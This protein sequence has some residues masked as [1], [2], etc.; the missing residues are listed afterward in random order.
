MEDTYLEV[1]SDSTSIEFEDK[2]S[3]RVPQILSD[4]SLDSDLKFYTDLTNTFPLE[5]EDRFITYMCEIC[6]QSI[7]K[8]DH[9]SEFPSKKRKNPQSQLILPSM[10]I[11]KDCRGLNLDD[12]KNLCIPNHGKIV[13]KR[14]R[15]KRRGNQSEKIQD[16]KE[17]Q[18]KTIEENP[19]LCEIE[20]KKLKQIIRNRISAQQSR[21]RKKVYLNK[22]EEDNKELKL[23]NNLLKRKV[24]DLVQENEYLKSQLSGIHLSAPSYNRIKGLGLGL[25]VFIGLVVLI[26]TDSSPIISIKKSRYLLSSSFNM[27]N[28]DIYS[29]SSFI[30]QSNSKNSGIIDAYR[31]WRINQIDQAPLLDSFTH[32]R[33]SQTKPR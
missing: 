4:I 20:K 28:E 1:I 11:C 10:K 30:A 24:Y 32:A 29:N 8:I 17:N 18:E 31:Q 9:S 15:A 22:L 33:G 16:F 26:T 27:E 12:L 21:D 13:I 14:E 3:D 6:H 25:V 7:I 23:Q 2:Y 19:N 5:P